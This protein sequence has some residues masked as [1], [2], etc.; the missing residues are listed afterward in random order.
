MQT[1]VEERQSS[2]SHE[3]AHKRVLKQLELQNAGLTFSVKYGDIQNKRDM[4]CVYPGYTIFFGR[5]SFDDFCAYLIRTEDKLCAMP[6]DEDYLRMLDNAAM[7]FS[8]AMLWRDILDIY[9]QATK[10]VSHKT[11]EDIYLK[12]QE[13]KGAQAMVRQVFLH[14][15]YGMIA[16]GNRP[17]Y[18]L[19]GMVKAMAA[20][21][22]LLEGIDPVTAANESRMYSC[23]ELRELCHKRGINE[24]EVLKNG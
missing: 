1:N 7:W 24:T 19:G 17:G 3:E 12:S 10:K 22:V 5:G 4:C 16:D 2:V 9:N 18:K 11:L 13:Y 6:L 8:A 20:R 14:L 23:E 15:Y 21:R